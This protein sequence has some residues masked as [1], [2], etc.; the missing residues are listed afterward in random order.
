MATAD[1][2]GTQV[3]EIHFFNKLKPGTQLKLTSGFSLNVNFTPDGKTAVARLYQ[4]LKDN[5]GGEQFFCSVEM[6]GVFK[7]SGELDDAV[8]KQLHS[9]CYDDLFP[10]LQRQVGELCAS[11]GIPNLMLKKSRINP[12]NVVVQNRAAQP[13]RQEP[14]LPIY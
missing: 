11:S 14:T 9:Q 8:K 2:S 7:L 10:Y 12:E 13:P 3:L 4:S 6:L 5:G 1:L